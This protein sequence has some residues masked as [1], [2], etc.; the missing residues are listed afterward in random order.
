MNKYYLILMGFCW[1]AIFLFSLYMILFYFDLI[2]DPQ[3]KI[4][5]FVNLWVF[6]ATVSGAFIIFYMN[7]LSEFKVPKRQ[8]RG[9]KAASRGD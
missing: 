6:V 7:K 3:E 2:S 8:K 1:A 5:V 4:K 9:R